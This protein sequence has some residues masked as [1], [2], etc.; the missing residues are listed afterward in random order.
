MKKF[1]SK[2]IDR[3]KFIRLAGL[4]TALPL[5]LN[6]FGVRAYSRNRFFDSLLNPNVITD[7][8]LVLIQLSGGNDGLNMVIPLD[9]YATYNSLRTNIALPETSV[10][11]LTNATGIHPGM[12]GIKTLYDAGKVNVVQSVTYPNPNLS[13]FR[14]NDIWMTGANY[15]EYLNTGWLGRYLEY[16]YPTYPDGYPN[17]DMPDPLAVQMS[18]VTSVAI[19]GTGRTMGIAL[20]NPDTF[21][22]LVSG[23][24]SG[25]TDTAPQT[26]AGTELTYLRLI[27]TQSQQYASAIKK[28]ADKAKNL[29]A[30]PTSNSL[31]DQL[32]IVARLIAGGLKTRVYMVSLGGFDLHSNAVLTTDTTQGAHATLLTKISTA[33]SAF[34]SDLQLLNAENRVISMTFSEFGRRVASNSSYGTDHGTAEPMFIFGSGV[35]PGVTGSNPNLS[36]LT[37]GN[38]K[39]QYDFRQVYAS[40]MDSWFGTNQTEL[41]TIKLGTFTKLPIIKKSATSVT[42]NSINITEYKLHQNYPN[43]FNPSTTIT[44][45]LPQESNVKLI[46]YDASGREVTTI[47]NQRQSRGTYNFTFNA[48]N[49]S[50]GTYY[51]RLEAGNVVMNKRM[52]L[53]K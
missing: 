47:V 52:V 48:N 22:Q 10:L 40:V 28:A 9:Q 7:K 18:A 6:G 19:Q 17:T 15:D 8:V 26:P 5:V 45:D 34:I 11:K 12:Q 37:S 39:M 1:D 41:N 50:S 38:L 46:V 21:Y 14:S 36:D 13:H 25:G 32:K 35:N 49:I 30:Y 51:Y 44:Y 24:Q 42:E 16:E 33:V 29:A 2:K 3:R 31:S 43:P 27:E 20:Q 23:S 4:S 53:I